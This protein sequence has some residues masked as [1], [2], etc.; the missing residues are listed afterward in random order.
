MNF[1][2]VMG[3]GTFDAFPADGFDGDIGSVVFVVAFEDVPV[4]SGADFP[5]ED[6]VVDHLGHI[7]NDKI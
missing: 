2:G 5:F 6:V 7:Y 3:V 4:L 1:P